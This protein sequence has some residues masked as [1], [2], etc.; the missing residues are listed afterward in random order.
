MGRSLQLQPEMGR[1][2]VRD[3]SCLLDLST[4]VVIKMHRIY[5]NIC[6]NCDKYYEGRGKYYCSRLCSSKFT[7]NSRSKILKGRMLSPSTQFKSGH[8]P[9]NINKTKKLKCIICGITFAPGDIKRNH[10]YCS[11]K[12]KGIGHSKYRIG[13]NS[14][15]WKGGFTKILHTWR[16]NSR[17]NQWRNQVLMRDNCTCQMCGYQK[18]LHAHHIKL[19][20]EYPE[21][22]FDINNG[23]TL[24]K[25]CHFGE[26]H[27]RR[28]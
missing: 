4:M 14:S 6:K 9:W 10:K 15:N 16:H 23:L 27:G 22:R 1:F 12:C 2:L 13:E 7:A 24:C 17:H 3:Q 8:I 18:E 28:L 19:L 26:V 11:N 5:K 20:S 21:L 25:P